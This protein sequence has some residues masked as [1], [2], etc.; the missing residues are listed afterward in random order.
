MSRLTRRGV[1]ARSYA[2]LTAS[3]AP[4]AL[5]GSSTSSTVST[6]GSATITGAGGSGSYSYAWEFVSGSGAISAV[7]G[8]SQTS[9]FTAS[10]L[11][12]GQ[13]LAGV[14]RGKVTDTVTGQVATTSNTVSISLNRAFDAITASLTP[15]SLTGSGTGTTVTTSGSVSVTVSGGSGSYTYAWEYVSGSST[16]APVSGSSATTQFTTTS[17]SA[18]ATQDAVWR[19]LVNDTVSG[20]TT[21]TSNNVSVSLTRNYTAL[22]ASVSPGSLSG[23][24]SSAPV[25]TSGSATVTASGGSGSYSYF[26]FWDGTGTGGLNPVDFSAPVVQFTSTSGQAVGTITAGFYCRVTDSITGLTKDTTSVAISLTGTSSGITYATASPL[27]FP[28]WD[29]PSNPS[30]VRVTVNHDGIGPF[31]YSWTASPSLGTTVTNSTTQ[32]ATFS[33]TNGNTTIDVTCRVTDNGAGG[34]FIITDPIQI[35]GFS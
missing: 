14:W 30:P 12:E 23:S 35:L 11:S 5:S 4:T 22:G 1:I 15:V 9:G 10:G 6:S 18:G 8:S 2:T 3:L 21:Y 34:I 13:T 19:C 31:T 16:P 32:T 26:W 17:I 7:S 33:R 27:D 20:Q 29:A 25:T 28:Q 24:S